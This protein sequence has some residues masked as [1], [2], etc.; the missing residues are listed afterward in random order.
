MSTVDDLEP[1]DALTFRIGEVARKH[2]SLDNYLRT[3][4]VTLTAPGR[5]AFLT[6]NIQS[7]DTLIEGCQTCSAKRTWI[8]RFSMAARPR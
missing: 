1:R 6:N 5:G 3:L 7:T 2:T 4:Y 8:S